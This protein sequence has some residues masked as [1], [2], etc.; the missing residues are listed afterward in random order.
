MFKITR[1]TVLIA[2][3]LTV[4][5]ANARTVKL[6]Y[7]L[8]KGNLYDVTMNTDQTIAIT[9]PNGMKME[10]KQNIM[11]NYD[12]KVT[13]VSDE[14]WIKI[15]VTYKRV[16]FSQI[17][18][19]MSVSFDSENPPE[20]IPPQA[21]AFNA[22]AGLSFDLS[23]TR[24]GKK[25]EIEGLTDMMDQ[26]VDKMNIPEEQKTMKKRQL[27]T[28]FGGKAFKNQIRQQIDVFP[29]E[30]V[31]VGDSWLK[32]VDAVA[33]FPMH[34]STEY[35]LEKIE[36]EKVIVDISSD[37]KT[38]KNP[39]SDSL[40]TPKAELSGEQNGKIEFDRKSG[41]VIESVFKQNIKGQMTLG[42]KKQPM[43]VKSKVTVTSEKIE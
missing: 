24:D 15:K 32:E 17:M 43:A 37:I 2:T 11:F 7:N 28:M 27:K 12:Y 1:I 13:D 39:D 6:E 4:F 29:E 42:N 9:K 23:F 30:K 31:A 21:Q 38:L 40:P 8:S 34:I 35:T 16:K 25:V 18:P 20:Q 36:K 26:M 10:M 33:S 22:L 5:S 19:M 14:D 41:M 3:F